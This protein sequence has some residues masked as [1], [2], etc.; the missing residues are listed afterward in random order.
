[1]IHPTKAFYYP[2]EPVLISIKGRFH[3]TIWHLSDIVA[4]MDGI[5]Q[6]EWTPPPTAKRGYAVHI[7]Q[8][9]EQTWTAFDVLDHWTDAPRYGYLFDFSPGREKCD[10]R[11]LVAHHINAL[12]FYD[13]LYRHDT[14]FP[15]QTDYLDPLNRPLSLI[16]VRTLIEAAHHH[17]MA[18][19]P[20]TAI[21]A[22]SPDF[23]AQHPDWGFYDVDGKLYDFAAGFLKIMNLDSGWRDHFVN[24]CKRILCELPFDGIHV[25]QYG[26]PRYGFNQTGEPV[27][28]PRHLTLTLKALRHIMADDKVL[29]FNLVH[30]HPLEE[31]GDAPLDF[32]YCELWEPQTTLGDLARV[33]KLNR[34]VSGGT[35][36]VIAAYISPDNEETIKLAQCVIAASGAYHLAHG[37]NGL[38]LCDPYFPKAQPVSQELAVYLKRIADFQVAYGELLTFAEPCSLDVKADVWCISRRWDKGLVISLLNADPLL[39]WTQGLETP[40]RRQNISVG[41]KIQEP[42]SAVWCISPDQEM[43]PQQLDY[44]IKDGYIDLIVPQLDYW[45]LIYTE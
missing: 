39:R 44:R 10:L 15:P 3:A 30:N 4:E 21:Y 6:L 42:V 43:P 41:L 7:Q 37:E 24:E 45:T 5:D 40:A 29:L 26:E 9:Q 14:P 22:A 25:D 17:H 8:G 31:M 27:N 1:M 28:L 16:T 11:W 38:F 32:L 36:P 18:A 12:Q 19:M 2:H 20:Y 35:S 33:A 23:A 13:W 34:K